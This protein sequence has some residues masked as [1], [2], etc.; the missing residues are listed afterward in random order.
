MIIVQN[1][2]KSPYTVSK[3]F[4]IDGIE[5]KFPSYIHCFFSK[6]YKITFKSFGIF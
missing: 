3:A 2:I 6:Y 5:L 4:N 1:Q